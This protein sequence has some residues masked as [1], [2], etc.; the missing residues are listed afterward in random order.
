MGVVNVTP[1]SFSDG[2][3]FLDPEAAVAHGLALVDGGRRGARRRAASPPARG[4]R[5]STRPRSS[6]RVAPGDPR[7][8]PRDRRRAGQHRHHQ[9]RRSPPRALDAGATIVNDVSAGRARS[10]DAR[11]RRRRRVPATSR[12]TCRAS[13]AR[14]RTT[15]TTTTSSREVGDFLV[16]RLDAARGRRHRRRRARWPIPASG[17]ARPLD[18]QPRR[19]SPRSPTLVA[20][21]RRAGARRDVAQGVPRPAR[22]TSRRSRGARRRHA[23]HGG[24]GARPRRARWCGCTT[25]AAAAQAAACSSMRVPRRRGAHDGGDAMTTLRGRWAQGLEPRFFCWIIKDRLAASERPGGFARNH[26]KIRRQEELIWLGQHGFT[27]VISLLDSPHNLHAYD[28]AG[29]AYEHVPLGRHDEL[30]DRL[31]RDLRDARAPAR[32][33]DGAGAHPPRGVRRPAARRARRL[34]ALR[35]PRRRGSARDRR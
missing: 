5:R 32:R 12:C 22:S 35:G 3:R 21:R 18:A 9:G 7:R 11:R 1:D 20:A 31:P 23:R 26:R 17:S 15:R 34:P 29:I 27:R 6:R 8:S 14:C 25:S 2:G 33:P 30:A 16:E 10:G 28:E 24:V 13:R 19:C 4:R